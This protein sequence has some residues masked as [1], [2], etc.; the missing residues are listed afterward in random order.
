MGYL[1]DIIFCK[2]KKKEKKIT[3]LVAPNDWSSQIYLYSAFYNT[4]CI[5]AVS[6]YQSRQ[7]KSVFY[8]WKKRQSSLVELIND[9]SFNLNIPN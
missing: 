5:K 1:Y 3:L 8:S 2:K 9:G 6:Q 4:D 7:L